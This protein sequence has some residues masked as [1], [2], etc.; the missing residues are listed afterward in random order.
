MYKIHP[1]GR[2]LYLIYFVDFYATN[3]IKCKPI[4]GVFLRAFKA[5]DALNKPMRQ[6]S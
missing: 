3:I 6:I 1:L 2:L 4:K 5:A